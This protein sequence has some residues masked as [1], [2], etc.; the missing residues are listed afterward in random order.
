MTLVEKIEH[1]YIDAAKARDT[2]KIAIVRLLKSALK[3][4]AIKISD[5]HYVLSDAEA[6]TVLNREAKQRRDSI[7][8]YEAGG[9]TDLADQEKKEL[10]FIETYLPKALSDE[11]LGEVVDRILANTGATQKA[12]MGKVMGALKAELTNPAD[13]SRAAALVSGKLA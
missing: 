9:R 5:L 2:E 6:M 8:Q 3:N 11:E 12:D 13:V 1:D 7:E 10:A 4:E